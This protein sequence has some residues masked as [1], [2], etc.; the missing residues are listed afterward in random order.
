MCK[1][2]VI[3]A[4]VY[5]YWYKYVKYSNSIFQKADHRNYALDRQISVS[6]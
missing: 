2:Y 1:F 5:T 4:K 6:Q 3:P